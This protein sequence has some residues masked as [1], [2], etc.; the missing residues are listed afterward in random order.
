LGRRLEVD[1]VELE[2]VPVD[3]EAVVWVP[4]VCAPLVGVVVDVDVTVE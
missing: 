3:V 4:V 1:G 2:V